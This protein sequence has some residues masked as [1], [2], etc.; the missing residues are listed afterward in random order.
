MG[1]EG[2]ELIRTTVLSET[3]SYWIA[4]VGLNTYTQ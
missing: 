2:Q 3:G 4:K 1:K